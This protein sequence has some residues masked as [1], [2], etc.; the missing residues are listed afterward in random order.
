MN[1]LGKYPDYQALAKLEYGRMLWK[2]EGGRKK[3]LDNWTHPAHPHCDRFPSNRLL[4]EMLLSTDTDYDTLDMDLR[5]HGTSL[6]AAM[7]E[8]PSYFPSIG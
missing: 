2:S 3:L 7:R 4:V 5:N 1:A 8:L 6:R